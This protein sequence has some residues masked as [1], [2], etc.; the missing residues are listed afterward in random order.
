MATKEEVTNRV[1]NG[2]KS[3]LRGIIF[4]ASDA[5]SGS[6]MLDLLLSSHTEIESVGELRHLQEY[7]T[8]NE[9][10]MCGRPITECHFWSSVEGEVSRDSQ[11]VKHNGLKSLQTKIRKGK[12]R[13]HQYL[14]SFIEIFLIFASKKM[15]T[16]WGKYFPAVRDAMVTA[17]NCIHICE[18]VSRVSGCPYIVDSSK[19]AEQFKAVYL[20]RPDLI[21]VIYL[22]R[23]GRGVACSQLRRSTLDM[24]KATLFWVLNNVKIMLM[25]L[26][27]PNEKVLFVRYED[28]C[29]N[30]RFEIPRILRFIG[31][32]GQADD[33]RVRKVGGHNV[34]G[35]P[36]RFDRRQ[37]E[38]IL[39]EGWKERLSKADLAVFQRFGASVNR[40]LGYV[41]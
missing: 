5:R 41:E 11:F 26:T 18:A 38:I 7:Y 33:L 20:L 28:L 30:R 12:H 36:H 16:K 8:N 1:R 39:D 31:V 22:V 15:A 40:W 19:W 3:S 24:K 23:D 27:V 25:K 35:S 17:E 2:E 32:M 4:I 9:S 14:P 34:G 29:R 10:C 37:E 6:T 13:M 21:K